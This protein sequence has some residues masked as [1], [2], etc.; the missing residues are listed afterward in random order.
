MLQNIIDCGKKGTQNKIILKLEPA[1]LQMLESGTC[2]N[3]IVKM[4]DGYGL[5]VPSS[6]IISLKGSHSIDHSLLGFMDKLRNN[7]VFPDG[8]QCLRY[9]LFDAKINVI[10]RIAAG[11][12]TLQP[13]HMMALYLYTS[14]YSIFKHVNLTLKT[15]NSSTSLNM[16]YSFINCLY[17]AINLLPLYNGEVYRGVNTK[18]TLEDYTIGNKITWN[19][20]SLGSY[21]WKNASDLIDKKTGVIFIIHSKSGRIISKYS[22]YPVDAEVIFLPGTSFTIINHYNADRICLGQANIRNTTFKIKENDYVKPLNG[23][24][25]IIIELSED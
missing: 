14:N 11:E 10:K 19:S 8:E 21:E 20:F 6:A 9:I 2:E 16:W 17:G 5:K 13:N 18:F 25:A 12:T 23:E 1:K 24:S 22:K 3:S 4:S 7:K 15:W